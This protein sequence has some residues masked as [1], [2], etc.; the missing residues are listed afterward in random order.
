VRTAFH[1]EIVRSI[2]RSRSRF[3]AIFAI[4]AL[5][6]GFYA[7]LRMCAPDMRITVDRYLDETAFM[8]AHLISTLGFSD[9]DVAA[10]EQ[11]AGV[12]AV[13]P[14]HV[15]DVTAT[16]GDRR[17][18]V[19][20]HELDTQ[21]AAASD[22]SSGGS[23]VSDDPSYLNRPILV[24][25]RWPQRSGESVIDRSKIF[26]NTAQIGQAVSFTAGV[27]PLEDTFA[28]TRF[29]IVGVVD[30]SYYLAFNRGS[31]TLNDGS[32]DRVM[33][34]PSGDFADPATYT[35]L[36]LSIEGAAE[37]FTF[38]P[39]YRAVV[40]PVARTLE[41]L[42][43]VRETARLAQVKAEAQETLDEKRAEYDE[44]KA[45]ADAQLADAKAKLDAAAA[46]IAS[47]ERDLS[48]GQ[49]R[50]QAGVA[51]LAAQR[52]SFA[53]QSA[54]VQRQIDTGR[55]A[56]AAQQAQLDQ[57]AAALSA[58]QQQIATLQATAS[59]L[60]AAYEAALAAEAL[61]NVVSP[62]SAELAASLATVQAQLG[63]AEQAYATQ[64]ATYDAGAAA[65][66]S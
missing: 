43:P 38:D 3:A 54:D 65:L 18:T 66:A 8:D 49:R 32:I 39:Q 36:F 62:S 34:I 10:V 13:M 57:L 31:T 6:A 29:T 25:G 53:T 48:A 33:Y 51:E 22:T 61:G 44:A 5:G 58:L 45:D 9:A 59:Q 23:A 47:S 56:L 41:A 24:A 2:V 35:D 12:A 17:A 55:A 40:Q 15:A 52:K 63:A 7:G 11:A 42:A 1:T 64:S 19:R 37:A 27:G 4:V 20:V 50:Y 14:A 46:T 30:S 21:A 28:R 26:A 60:Q 16:I